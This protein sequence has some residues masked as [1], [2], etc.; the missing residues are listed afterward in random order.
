MVARPLVVS[1][2]SPTSVTNAIMVLIM[3]TSRITPAKVNG[4]PLAD[5]NPALTSFWL[6]RQ[7]QRPILFAVAAIVYSMATVAS[8]LIYRVPKHRE[9]SV[10]MRE[11]AYRAARCTSR[12]PKRNMVGVQLATVADGTS[13]P[14]A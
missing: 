12:H 6:N 3:T 1:C 5:A 14:F 8:I 10:N 9:L 11:N 7:L 13:V 2:R 4:A